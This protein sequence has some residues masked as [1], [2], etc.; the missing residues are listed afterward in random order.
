MTRVSLR[1]WTSLLRSERLRGWGL[2]PPLLALLCWTRPGQAQTA[3]P[4]PLQ[5]RAFQ[6]PH[7]VVVFDVGV[8]LMPGTQVCLRPE[9]CT[10]SR[11]SLLLSAWPLYRAS[12]HFEFGAGLGFAFSPKHE[13]IDLTSRVPRTHSS[14]IFMAEGTARYLPIAGRDYQA[15]LGGTTGFVVVNDSFQIEQNQPD[16]HFVG[17]N[18]S[19]IASEGLA[20]GVAGGMDWALG[21]GIRLGGMLRAALWLLPSSP[22]RTALGDTASLDG[23]VPMFAGGLTFAYSPE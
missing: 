11:P 18:G 17:E 15:W 2:L 10:D 21:S 4:S 20:V 22:K 1:C 14:S 12:E 8:L 16:Q 19:S 7:P 6:R 3:S 23:L 9:N 5:R 13:V